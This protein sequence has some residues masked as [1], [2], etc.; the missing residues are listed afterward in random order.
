M[1]VYT[2]LASLVGIV[3]FLFALPTYLDVFKSGESGKIV[4][5]VVVGI[6]FVL[7]SVIFFAIF[8]FLRFHLRLIF[9]NQTTIETLELSRQGKNPEEAVSIYD[10]GKYSMR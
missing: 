2:I 1:L 5:A 3:G 7:N 4:E 8:N 10:I 6:A 9:Y